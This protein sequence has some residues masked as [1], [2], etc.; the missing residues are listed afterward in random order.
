MHLAIRLCGEVGGCTSIAHVWYSPA[1]TV[2]WYASVTLQPWNFDEVAPRMRKRDIV[3][4]KS[5]AVA[6]PSFP[7][8]HLLHCISAALFA[9]GPL[10]I[11]A[12]LS[13]C[14]PPLERTASDTGL[15]LSAAPVQRLRSPI[16][17]GGPLPLSCRGYLVC[18]Y[19][20][21][22]WTACLRNPGGSKTCTEN[23]VKWL[24]RQQNL[25]DPKGLM[26]RR[27]PR[28]LAKGYVVWRS[29]FCF[30]LGF[31]VQGFGS[32]V[33]GLGLSISCPSS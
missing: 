8:R 26:K 31:S 4:R 11:S 14:G 33:W 16:K 23:A 5:R 2:V 12:A 32:G 30:C 7:A 15:P 22:P 25:K 20:V 10:Q 17:G 29:V 21:C 6:R 18:T 19:L 3:D 9:R 13:A 1:S 24:K 28:F 27:W